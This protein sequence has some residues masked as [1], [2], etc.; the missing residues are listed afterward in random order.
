MTYGDMKFVKG[1]I[2]NGALPKAPLI[3]EDMCFDNSDTEIGDYIMDEIQKT[4]KLP[5]YSYSGQTL[6]LKKGDVLGTVK[7]I[8]P[9]K[10]ERN[11]DSIHAAEIK[12]ELDKINHGDLQPEDM[13]KLHA[14]LKK[15]TTL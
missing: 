3:Y 14:M 9:V 13:A 7:E 12:L 15:S 10:E 2:Q 6:K 4:V 1:K 5:V 8:E 11:L